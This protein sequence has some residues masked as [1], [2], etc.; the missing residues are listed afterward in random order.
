MFEIMLAT[1][2]NFDMILVDSLNL[3]FVSIAFV[4][5]MNTPPF[6]I[7]FRSAKISNNLILNC[8]YEIKFVES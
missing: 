7:I 1:F 6:I 8:G 4:V 3:I 5:F 2:T